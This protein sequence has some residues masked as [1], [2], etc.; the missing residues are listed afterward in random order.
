MSWPP[1]ALRLNHVHPVRSFVANRNPAQECD[2]VVN[3]YYE[4]S[5]KGRNID[6]FEIGFV[7]EIAEMLF[8]SR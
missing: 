1:F 2:P 7:G 8:V 3:I 6:I 5:S 4:T